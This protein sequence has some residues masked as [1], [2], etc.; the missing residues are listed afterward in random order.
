MDKM[1]E[2]KLRW[3]GYIMSREDSEAVRTVMKLS[4]EGRR[5]R[6]RSKKKWLNMI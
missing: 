5:G 1:R 2:N 6:G 4:M 3:F